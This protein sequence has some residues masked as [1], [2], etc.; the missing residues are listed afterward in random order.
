M[1]VRILARFTETDHAEFDTS[2]R[3]V[4]QWAKRHHKS[5]LVNYVPPDVAD[6]EQE[7]QKVE[8]W[9]DRVKRYKN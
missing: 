1:M 7:L 8:V 2:Y 3:R 6:H 5:V 4:S 9:F